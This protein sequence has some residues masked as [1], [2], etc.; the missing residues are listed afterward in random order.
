MTGF[1]RQLGGGLVG[2]AL[3]S[4]VAAI[5]ALAQSPVGPVPGAKVLYG[6]P[7]I[8]APEEPAEPRTKVKRAA[9]DVCA[10][11]GM[12]RDFDHLAEQRACSRKAL[13]SA[14]GRSAAVRW[15]AELSLGVRSMAAVHTRTLG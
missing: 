6:K 10:F 9:M 11:E 14:D 12:L 2:A 1:I 7:E 8:P 13:A 5:P 15:D 4:L 3:L